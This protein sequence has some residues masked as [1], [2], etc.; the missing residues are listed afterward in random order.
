MALYKTRAKQRAERC[1]PASILFWWVFSSLALVYNVAGL[2][3]R[4]C[5][6]KQQKRDTPPEYSRWLLV[7]LLLACTT[8]ACR[9]RVFHHLWKNRL[10]KPFRLPQKKSNRCQTKSPQ[11][12]RI[13]HPFLNIPTMAQLIQVSSDHHFTPS[14]DN[15]SNHSSSFP[16]SQAQKRKRRSIRFGTSC[17]LQLYLSCRVYANQTVSNM[18]RRTRGSPH[19]T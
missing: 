2:L 6:W 16:S 12:Q 5:G 15:D 9:P 13:K 7:L 1:H 10:D 8:A 3:S 18:V 11:R 19:P 14:A 17:R 4:G